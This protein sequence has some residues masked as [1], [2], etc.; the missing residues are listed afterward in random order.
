[1][2]PRKSLNCDAVLRRSGSSSRLSAYIHPHTG[3]LSFVRSE[4]FF[5]SQCV[6]STGQNDATFRELVNIAGFSLLQQ[7]I[8][9]IHEL[10][11]LLEPSL[12]TRYSFYESY[13]LHI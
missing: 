6:P 13:S 3:S 10:A 4:I 2:V 9:N 8:P 1:M 7:L 12:H 5:W 11:H